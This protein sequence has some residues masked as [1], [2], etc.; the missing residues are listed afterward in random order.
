MAGAIDPSFNTKL[1]F[2]DNTV[3]DLAL[4]SDGKLIIGSTIQIRNYGGISRKGIARINT[5]GTLDPTFGV[6]LFGVNKDKEFDVAT[7][8]IKV[9]SSGKILVSGIYR[10][11]TGTT[12]SYSLVRLNSDGSYDPSFTVTTTA[13]AP[14]IFTTSVQS[15]DKILL[16]GS[17][18]SFRGNNSWVGIARVNADGTTDA[19]FNPGSGFSA[20]PTINDIATQADGKHILVGSFSTYNGTSRP[21]IVRINTN[22]SIDTSFTP[23]N[24]ADG[25]INSVTIRSDGKI[26]IG[27]EFTTYNGSTRMRVARLNSD[28][29]LDGTFNTASAGQNGANWAVNKVLVH[30]DNKIIIGGSFSTYQ[31]TTR[32]Y[33]AR[34]NTDGS[35]DTTF[36]PSS[37]ANGVLYDIIE[38]PSGKIIVAGAFSSFNGEAYQRIVRLTTISATAPVVS[39]FTATATTSGTVNLSWSVNDGGG[40]LSAYT[41]T[42]NGVSITAPST[43]STTYTDNNA[44]LVMGTSYTYSLVAQN[45]AGSSAAATASAT[46]RRAPTISAFT[47]TT[48]SDGTVSLSWSVNNGGSALTKYLLKRDGVSISDPSLNSTTYSDADPT[49]TLGSTYLYSLIAEN[50]IGASVDISASTIPRVTFLSQA[51]DRSQSIPLFVQTVLNP[52]AVVAIPS[53]ATLKQVYTNATEQAAKITTLFAALRTRERLTSPS[54]VSLSI[55]SSTSSGFVSLLTQKPAVLP[56][57]P[58]K[59]VVDNS[60]NVVDLGDISNTYVYF[61]LPQTF[62]KGTQWIH[63]AEDYTY[64]TS[65]APTP[66]AF[67]M[68]TLVQAGGLAIQM[69]G[70]G[71][72]AGEFQSVFT[73][74]YTSRTSTAITFTLAGVGGAALPTAVTVTSQSSIV[75]NS[76]TGVLTI[77]GLT[78]GTAYSFVIN[79]TGYVSVTTQTITPPSKPTITLAEAGAYSAVI[80][81]NDGAPG[82]SPVTEYTVRAYISSNTAVAAKTVTTAINGSYIMTGLTAFETYVFSVAATSAEG[83]S[84]DSDFSATV[85][86]VDRVVCFLEN[87]PVLTPSGY[88]PIGGLQIGDIVVT[89]DG[90]HVP[91]RRVNVMTC[92][93]SVDVNPYVIKQGAWG[94]LETLPISPNHR[95][96]V[97][98]NVMQCAKDLGL[99]QMKMKKA[100]RY[101]NLELPNWE[102]DNMVVA[103]VV[104]ESLVPVRRVTAALPDFIKMVNDMYGT[105][106]DEQLRKICSVCR[107]LPNGDIEYPTFPRNI[108]DR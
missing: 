105:P 83:T 12:Q 46:P 18:T 49:L 32:N 93:P 66:V 60:V 61:A 16:G 23:G 7:Y 63:F 52:P 81:W 84:T 76:T 24:G 56:D 103:G 38:D 19:T 100:F 35:L 20:S 67:N 48:I 53:I 88:R 30:S 85:Q 1:N 3:A 43:G 91:V 59:I 8:S 47:A 44:G 25:T 26:M 89:A 94:A 92:L 34:L 54:A 11:F 28:G 69:R 33:I 9:L 87:A 73:A 82:G 39:A 64:T 58:V 71:S 70:L 42:R 2:P 96:R 51:L 5:D 4:Q 31:G 6:G 99:K 36:N 15:D 22:G 90:R 17:F 65:V 97:E 86:V 40:A 106:S 79:A 10:Y 27:G 108:E 45:V 57:K 68:D 41:L 78:M 104:V 77:S 21:N 62:S 14:N 98:N 101:Y 75:Y 29:T 74:S 107:F 55:A 13:T 102:T 50:T 80:Y 37:G 72:G 95:V